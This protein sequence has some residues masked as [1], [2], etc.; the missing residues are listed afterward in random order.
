MRSFPADGKWI[1]CGYMGFYWLLYCNLTLGTLCSRKGLESKLVHSLDRAIG[2]VLG[3]QLRAMNLL[4]SIPTLIAAAAP[5]SLQSCPTL[6]DPIDGSPPGSPILE[7]LQARVLERAAITFS[8]ALVKPSQFAPVLVEG[9]LP[10]C[11]WFLF[12]WAAHWKV[13]FLN[14][15]RS[16]LNFYF[17][18][19]SLLLDGHHLC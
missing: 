14:S 11:I 18:T 15:L 7:I 5:K 2:S 3:Q 12:I 6:C 10:L 19:D 13:Q 9:P 1:L 17:G 4:A 16:N 8:P